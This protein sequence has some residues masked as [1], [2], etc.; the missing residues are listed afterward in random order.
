[1]NLNGSF[2][3]QLYVSRTNLV[4]YLKNSGFDCKTIENSSIEDMEHMKTYNQ[5]DFKVTN[6]ITNE[7]CYI[8]Y[9]LDENFKQNI[10]KRNN[11]EQYINEVYDELKILENKDTLII[12]TNEYTKDSVNKI[13]KNM[14][15]KENKYVVVFTLSNLQ[16]NIL[17]HSYV[18]KHTRLNTIQKE[19][20]FKTY[21][22]SNDKQLPE[23]SRFDPVSK[24]IFLRPGEVCEIIRYDKISLM[25]KYYRVC[26]S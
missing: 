6:P 5:L 21:N 12:V 4:Y 15:E 8:M 10:I 1:M 23:I 9:K 7:S 14:W 24:V 2:I 18:P 11:I 16:T 22:L 17:L 13:L 19:E 26:V 20:V 25:N 3:K